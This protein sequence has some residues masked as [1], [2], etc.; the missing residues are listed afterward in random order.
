MKAVVAVVSALAVL[1]L[2][3]SPAEARKHKPTKKAKHYRQYDVRLPYPHATERQRR[4]S[5]AFD[6]GEY[7]ESL[8]SEHA[9]GSR[10][11]WLL[12]QGRGGSRR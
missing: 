12:Q 2:I 3:A 8:P 4:N 7:Y 6:R 11:W 10:S 5:L 9:F 1:A